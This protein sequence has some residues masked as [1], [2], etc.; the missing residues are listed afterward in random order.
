MT[1]LG[2]DAHLLGSQRLRALCDAEI[3][4]KRIYDGQFVLHC[5]LMRRLESS[6]CS[7][8]SSDEKQQLFPL[9]KSR[10]NRFKYVR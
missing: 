10:G 4:D 7:C 8:R 5:S 6:R 3:L 2:R 1:Q 9:Q